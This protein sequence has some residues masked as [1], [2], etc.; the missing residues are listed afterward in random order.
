MT[1]HAI[2][3]S[4]R[5]MDRRRRDTAIDLGLCVAI[6]AFGLPP[7]LDPSVNNP[8]ATVVGPL[9]LPT[10]LLPILWRR[11][12]PLM[13]ACALAV[14]CVAS[15][16]PTFDQFRLVV[17]V[18]AGLLILI[19]LATRCAWNRA[20]YGL[21][22]VLA[23][24]GFV[25]ASESVLDGVGGFAST[26]VFLVPLCLA[27]WGAGRIVW[28]RERVAAQLTA[29]SDQ[30]GRQREATAALAVEIDRGRLGA[31]LDVAARSRLKQMIDLASVDVAD[32]AEARARFS[33]IEVLGRES[34]DQMRSLLGL[35]R[36]VDRGARA[37]RPTLEQLDGLIADARAGGRLVDLQIDGEH[38]PLGAGIELAAYRTVQHAL[39]AV[40]SA[41]DDPATVRL[42]YFPDRLELEVRGVTPDGSAAGA[43]MMAARE[44]V[45]AIGGNFAAETPAPGRRVLRA[46]LPAVTAV[47]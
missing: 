8:A 26:M 37:P 45:T 10:L 36:S 15:A 40:G 47:A 16:I 11:R 29:R 14:G 34:L 33:R 7:M 4:L 12:D 13:A 22:I 1:R 18:P 24:L 35:L 39:I 5:A 42:H 31:D 21:A 38:R 17:A 27:V 3:R 46:R 25:G 2:T 20:A 30:L 41:R 43:A 44:R 28:S 19:S 6:V 9:L 32:P 23:G